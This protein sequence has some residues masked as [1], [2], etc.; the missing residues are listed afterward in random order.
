MVYLLHRWN[1]PSPVFLRVLQGT[2]RP[3]ST[4]SFPAGPARSEAHGWALHGFSH[5]GPGGRKLCSAHGHG[6]R[7]DRRGAVRGALQL[8]AARGERGPEAGGRPGVPGLDAGGGAAPAAWSVLPT[9][10]RAGPPGVPAGV[11]PLAV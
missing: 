4:F 6:R 1:T 9:A 3:P 8:P 7:G 2:S 5:T 11:G 10:R